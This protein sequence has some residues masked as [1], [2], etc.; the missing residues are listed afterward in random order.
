[1]MHRLITG[2]ATL[3]LSVSVYANSCET[4]YLYQKLALNSNKS[5]SIQPN[6]KKYQVVH[7]DIEGLTP[8]DGAMDLIAHQNSLLSANVVSNGVK[9][10]LSL[11]NYVLGLTRQ[12]IKDYY[13]A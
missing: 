9:K 10:A 11:K 1:M 12:A 6:I 7:I 3:L 5:L 4:S 2:I 8:G 13:Y